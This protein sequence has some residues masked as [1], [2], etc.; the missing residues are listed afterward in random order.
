MKAINLTNFELNSDFAQV[1]SS[2]SSLLLQRLTM[3]H[4]FTHLF[5]DSGENLLPLKL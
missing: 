5:S 2:V 3:R 1:K 4:I